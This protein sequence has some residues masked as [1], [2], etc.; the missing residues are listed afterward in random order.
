MLT[1]PSKNYRSNARWAIGALAMLALLA[2]CYLP[3][4]F[5][6]EVRLGR[7]GDYALSFYGELAWAPLVRDIQD[8]KLSPEE[9]PAKIA[10]IKKDLARDS[11]F[12]SVESLGKGRF[13]VSYE[14]QGH[15]GPHA[16]V[17]FV[18]SNAIIIQLH[19]TPDGLIRVEGN[20]LRPADAQT[21]T[22]LGIDIQG[23]FRVVTDGLVK[24][25]NAGTVRPFGSATLYIWSIQNAFS[26]APHLVMQREGAWPA[27]EKGAKQ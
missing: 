5:K 1:P 18:R 20:T 17:I 7:T 9:I 11:N 15:L 25:H 21:L 13:K 26:P 16:E 10:M 19:S 22:Q 8:K 14:R 3:N 12:K 6:S 2:G 4:N 27:A 24:D 23:E